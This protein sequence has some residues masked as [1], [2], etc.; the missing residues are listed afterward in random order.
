M[1]ARVNPA[2]FVLHAVGWFVLTAA[3]YTALVRTDTLITGK[4]CATAT[5]AT[6]PAANTA[7]NCFLIMPSLFPSFFLL[8][9]DS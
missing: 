6:A 3:E 7:Q 5:A 4:F 8:P 2:T 9:S 1:Y